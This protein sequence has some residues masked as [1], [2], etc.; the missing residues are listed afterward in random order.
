MTLFEVDQAANRIREEVAE[1]ANI[2]FGS[3][4]DD[5]LAGRIRVSVVAT[6]IDTQVA[7]APEQNNP[8]PAPGRGRWWRTP[9]AAGSGAIGTCRCLSG[10]PTLERCRFGK[11]AGR[12]VRGRSTAKRPRCRRSPRR[13]P[14]RPRPRAV[15]CLPAPPAPAATSAP[16]MHRP[17]HCPHR[18]QRAAPHPARPGPGARRAADR[19]GAPNP[20]RWFARAMA[21]AG[22]RR[23]GYSGISASA[24][25]LGPHAHGL[26]RDKARAPPWPSKPVHNYKAPQNF[27][28][29]Q[30]LAPK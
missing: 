25:Q 5:G 2:I 7:Q 22:S 21:R 29:N 13:H 24:E 27:P 20:R 18:H 30:S 28:Q 1:D 3:A 6:G 14:I 23:A 9:A 10:T 26:R 4:V 8:R 16:G 15:G 17:Q 19:P 11:H 12:S